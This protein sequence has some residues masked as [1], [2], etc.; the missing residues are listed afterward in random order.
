MKDLSDQEQS[1][2]DF[3]DILRGA[4]AVFGGFLSRTGT[5]LA[6]LF[7]AG[8]LY[9]A[10][11]L[12]ELAFFLAV[13]ETLAAVAV[14]GLKK[15]LFGFV[16]HDK[17]DPAR[18]AAIVKNALVF[19]CGLALLFAIVLAGFAW[20][21]LDLPGSPAYLRFFSFIIPLIVLTDILL[22]ATRIT[23]VMRY[24]VYARSV[25]EPIALLLFALLFFFT[26]LQAEGLLLS[27]AGSIFVAFTVALYGYGS[28]LSF[29]GLVRAKISIRDIR[30]IARVSLPTTLADIGSLLIRRIDVFFLW[31]F[32]S[33][34]V[35]G[36]YYAVQSIATNIQK[37]RQ[38]FSPVL[39]PV[40]AQSMA[41]R[42]MEAAANRL[43]LVSRWIL[44]LQLAQLILLSLFAAPLLGLVGPGME[45]GAVALM[46]ILAG[47]VFEGTF[48][49]LDLPIVFRRPSINTYL[50]SAG[51]LLMAVLCYI[52]V[53]LYG[54][55]GAALSLTSVF[56]F[57]NGAR[58]YILKRVFGFSGL[59]RAYLKPAAA[60]VVTAVMLF[61][62]VGF[63][64]FRSGF[65]LAAVFMLTIF[66]YAGLLMLLGISQQD[67]DLYRMMR[68]RKK[69]R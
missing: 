11:A 1:V 22:T 31:H 13:V 49:L 58:L 51:L 63:P 7:V 65:G 29:Q 25:A 2:R 6:F 50:V 17:R 38:L 46:I 68:G 18:T 30:R 33:E 3:S 42:S 21:F 66:S 44:T 24:L 56:I 5:R 67:R 59:E 39:A 19:S 52:L 20:P 4:A 61:F 60:A 53:P 32:T 8:N 40:I 45:A 48:G 69:D 47:E 26:D 14:F 37:T 62:A 16:D 34:E 54:L 35:V 43:R 23:R 36:I 64:V 27:Y 41:R 55:E 12:G 9:G 28:L 10:A 15:S 57:I